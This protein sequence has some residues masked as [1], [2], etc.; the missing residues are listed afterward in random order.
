MHDPPLAVHSLALVPPLIINP[1][2]RTPLLLVCDHASN[3][4]PATLGNLGLTEEQRNDHIAWDPGAFDVA[5]YL[6]QA[7][8]APLIAG[9]VSRL[10]I[11]CNRDPMAED[12]IVTVSDGVTIPGN[13]HL[14]AAARAERATMVYAPFQEAIATHALALRRQHQRIAL[15]AIHSFTPVYQGEKRPWQIGLL[16]DPARPFYQMMAAAL[17]LCPE[18]CLGHNLPYSYFGQVYH[19]L[20]LHGG[21]DPTLLIELRNDLIRSP[22]GVA[23]WGRLLA[24]ALH[25]KLSCLLSPTL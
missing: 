7:L 9:S 16:G 1:Q 23:Q 12:S 11:D 15:L 6:A 18:L 2:G 24:D 20:E 4:I 8:D 21:N 14:S 10:V 13:Q 17:E 25:A 5:N 22:Q 3:T 19:T